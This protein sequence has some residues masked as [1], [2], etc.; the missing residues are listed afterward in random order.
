[1]PEPKEIL[2]QYWGFSE[3]RNNQEAIITSVL[4]KNDTFV[5]LPTGGGKSICY[6]VPALVLDGICV[7]ISPLIALIKDQV[8]QLEKKNIKSV[9][10]IGRLSTDDLSNLLDNCA[11]GNYK[12]LYLSPER[13][14]QDWVLERICNLPINLVAIDE[15]HCV[16]QWGHDFRRAYLKINKLKTKLP[17][18][19]FIALTATA[20]EKVKDDCIVQLQLEDPVVFKSSFKRD[21]LAYNVYKVEDKNYYLQYYLS[22]QKSSC[23]V[24]VRN[25]KAC[26]EKVALL[27][28]F[29]L[30]ATLYHGGLPFKE[31]EKNMALWMENKVQIMVATNAFGM[32]I[33][34]PDVSCVMHLE[35]PNNLENY[36]QEV[37]RAG[38]DGQLAQGI[39]LFHESDITKAKN[40]FI[41]QLPTVEDLQITYSKLNS[42]FKIAYGEGFNENFNFS[43]LEFC[44]RYS[45]PFG[46]THASLLYL[47]Q[48]GVLNFENE[49]SEKT[50]IKILL[51]HK[52]LVRFISLN[53]SLAAILTTVLRMYTGI[54]EIETLINPILIAQKAVCTTDELI[55][56]LEELEKKE[57]ISLSNNAND[58]SITFLQIR[59]D[60]YTI[61]AVKKHLVV[62]NELKKKQLQ[63]VFDFVK[64]EDICKS[65]I[66]LSYF[67]ER[68]TAN[69][70]ICSFCR[71][72]IKN[73]DTNI[74]QNQI[75]AFLQNQE[76]VTAR[77]LVASL[78]IESKW[79]IET[80]QLL[81]ENKTISINT[82]NKYYLL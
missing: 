39:L 57:V 63:A 82:Y 14:N 54:Y 80:I 31:K 78:H 70:G 28:S 11:F 50:K 38:R 5:L 52:E 64:N 49:Y 3:F 37:G 29:G 46:K 32:G 55:S 47:T 9:A 27:Q 60:N 24:Y 1:M 2:Q 40:Q 25:R 43:F 44:S 72:E 10:L 4:D 77:E 71:K 7:V 15:A 45:L 42:F 34:K 74:I 73:V 79:V 68:V 53:E 66:L 8:Q 26:S 17:N 22:R 6:Q 30:T 76:D 81:L 35:L 56:A 18:V 48:Q 41:N 19:P 59:D 58:S 33:D 36:F 65:R 21:N 62:Q 75:I 23:I 51:C 67:D 20:T 13:L 16:S 61:S 12:F 69:C